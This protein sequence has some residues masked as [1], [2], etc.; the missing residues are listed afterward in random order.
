MRIAV[1]I[2]FL[3]LAI[4]VDTRFMEAL[5]IGEVLPGIAGTL[6][7]FLVLCAQRSHALWACLAIG[8]FLDFSEF[9]LYDGDIASMKRKAS[10]PKVIGFREKTIARSGRIR[11]APKRKP[12]VYGPTRQ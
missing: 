10:T 5:R 2:L 4:V 3:V 9:A 6:A 7:V 11:F 8:L 1:F 12:S